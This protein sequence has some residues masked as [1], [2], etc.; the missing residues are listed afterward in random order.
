MSSPQTSIRRSQCFTVP[1]STP[2]TVERLYQGTLAVAAERGPRGVTY[3]SVAGLAGTSVGTIKY[4][5]ADLDELLFKSFEYYVESVSDRYVGDL[6]D[7]PSIPQLLEVLIGVTDEGMLSGP[8]DATLMYSLYA[9]A[10]RNDR[11]RTL[12]RQWMSRTRGALSAHMPPALA[13]QIE[14]IIE[15]A[16]VQK[17]IGEDGQSDDQLRQLLKAALVAGGIEPHVVSH[18]E[19]PCRSQGDSLSSCHE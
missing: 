7:A 4:H 14:A 10:A 18:P 19:P 5:F 9:H 16:I 3:R 12:V 11:Y 17:A 15:G 2:P 13:I 1:P 8:N 6:R